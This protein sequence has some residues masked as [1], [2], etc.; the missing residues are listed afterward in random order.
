MIQYLA[1]DRDGNMQRVNDG[2]AR[3]WLRCEKPNEDERAL[4]ITLGIDEDILHDALDPHE[5]PRLEL[6]GGWTY[7][8]TRVPDIDD[9]FNDFT[10]PMM[11]AF[12]AENYITVSRDALGRLWQPF[13]DS[14]IVDTARHKQLYLM[15]LDVIVQSYQKKVARINRQ[16]RAVTHNVTRLGPKQIATIVE[17]ERILNDYLD[18]LMPTNTSLEK[19]LSNKSLRFRE[20]DLDEIENLSV[21]LEQVITRCKAL[22][23]TIQNV[24]DSY[25]AVMDTRLNETMGLLTIVTV[26]MSIPT[27]LAGIMGM[28]VKF[29]FSTDS[30]LVFWEVVLVSLL[31]GAAVGYYFLKRR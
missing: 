4:L 1:S 5:V 21:D 6:D 17:Y 25:R 15:M 3:A 30:N 8:I 13:I 29:P 2:M 18:A 9:E 20:D 11:F 12:N 24:R 23:R 14:A 19:L 10:T 16:I 28:N 26:M 22:L 7:F 27:M 31:S